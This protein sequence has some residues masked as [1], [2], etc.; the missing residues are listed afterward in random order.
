MHGSPVA[1]AVTTA[2]DG[3]IL[4]ANDA[5]LHLTQF[6]RPEVIVLR[7]EAGLPEDEI[8]RRI[9]EAARPGACEAQAL[10]RA[11]RRGP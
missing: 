8:A 3:C 11:W 9:I 5:F 6:D 4:E 2:A 10:Q 1:I 7:N